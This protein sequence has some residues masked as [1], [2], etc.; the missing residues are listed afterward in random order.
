MPTEARMAVGGAV[1]LPD[2]C[3]A[4]SRQRLR[5]I[6][7]ARNWGNL[8]PEP[9]TPKEALRAAMVRSFPA[10]PAKCGI[11]H[12]CDPH[13]NGSAGYKIGAHR[14]ADAIHVGDKYTTAIATG[15]L[16]MQREEPEEPEE[17]KKA[18]KPKEVWTG[19]INLDPY[20]G[21]KEQE[22]LAYMKHVM[23]YVP[24]GKLLKVIAAIVGKFGGRRL[25]V[26][27]KVARKAHNGK[28]SQ[29]DDRDDR[30][31]DD[32]D[33]DDDDASDGSGTAKR[34][35]GKSQPV[36]W[37]TA[38]KIDEFKQIAGQIESASAKTDSDGEPVPSNE[39]H[40]L[41]IVADKAMA[42]AVIGMLVGVVDREIARVEDRLAQPAISADQRGN[43]IVRADAVYDELDGYVDLLDEP[44]TD[45][46]AKAMKLKVSI[47]NGVMDKALMAM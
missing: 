12:R 34:R 22:I 24:S 33:G 26:A 36:W 31:D 21:D 2:V 46:K 5:E 13:K 11:K 17:G 3:A 29:D 8:M 30:D 42:R 14:P 10:P 1:I 28:V 35:G 41:S 23:E 9:V 45:L 44:L 47:A 38:D 27:K 20:D 43:D 15:T 7:D 37:I 16:R 39:I 32:Q 25:I 6:L 19:E 18:R 40:V 4:T